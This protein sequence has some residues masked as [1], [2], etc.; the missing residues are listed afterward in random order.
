MEAGEAALGA[1]RRSE[2]ERTEAGGPGSAWVNGMTC[3]GTGNGK[4]QGEGYGERGRRR[5]AG[6]GSHEQEAR[7]EQMQMQ[8]EEVEALQSGRC[9]KKV[10]SRQTGWPVRSAEQQGWGQTRGLSGGQ[11]GRQRMQGARRVG[12]SEEEEIEALQAGRRE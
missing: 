9:G 4:P 5:S 12:P 7:G 11:W 2:M 6:G 3:E 10:N 8:E 1:G